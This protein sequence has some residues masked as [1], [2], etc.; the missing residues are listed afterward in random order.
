MHF[1]SF[2]KKHTELDELFC[3]AKASLNESMY[4]MSVF[5]SSIIKNLMFPPKYLTD[6]TI[7]Y[8][9]SY[10]EKIW[11]PWT[12]Y[13]YPPFDR[14]KLNVGKNV[15]VKRI[16]HFSLNWNDFILSEVA[17]QI[18][19]SKLFGFPHITILLSTNFEPQKKILT[20]NVGYQTFLASFII[21]RYKEFELLSK[22]W[23]PQFKSA[24]TC[25][26]YKVNEDFEQFEKILSMLIYD[27]S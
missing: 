8:V 2:L 5:S 21:I 17:C 4:K 1:R 19:H 12:V 14:H 25:K 3:F 11:Q 27:E 6:Y 23:Q 9:F 20:W 22:F 15:F 10:C 16:W 13:L 24:K 7:S 26:F 18:T